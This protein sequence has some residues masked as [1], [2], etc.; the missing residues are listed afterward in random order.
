VKSRI[1]FFVILLVISLVY[2]GGCRR[3]GEWL[4][5]DDRPSH[6]DA[7][8]MLMGGFSDRVLHASDLYREGISGRLFMVEDY[9]GP[10]R[11]LEE[12]GVEIITNSEQ[13]RNAAV[14]LGIPADSIEILPGEARST[15]SEAMVVRDMLLRNTGIDTLLIVSSASHTRRARI[16]FSSVF[17]DTGVPVTVLSSPS[18]Y[19]SFSASDWWKDKEGIQAVLSEYIKV[20][21]YL[22]FERRR[23]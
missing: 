5:K 17:R 4:V 2:I 11:M 18:S 15:L 6:A 12:R 9:M 3:A 7:M 20:A 19:T 23:P 8:I 22:I 21:S 1:I 13:V 16:I 14:H 10:Y